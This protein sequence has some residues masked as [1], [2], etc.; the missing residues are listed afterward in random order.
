MKR[1]SH[2]LVYYTAF[3][4]LGL[5]S[6]CLGPTLS[7]LAENTHSSLSA[8]SFLFTARSGGYLLGSL[9]AGWLY[10]RYRGHPLMSIALVFVALALFFVPLTPQLWLTT[11]VILLLGISESVLDVGT[12]TLL[13]WAYKDN[14]GPFM[15]G[16]HFAFGLGAFLSPIIVAQAV[17][18]TQGITWA[19]WSL[20]LLVLI[21]LPFIL[22]L[23]SP[24][25][26]KSQPDKKEEK[27]HPSRPVWLLLAVIF[28]FFIYAG[29][30]ISLGNWIYSYAVATKIATAAGAAYLNSA[31]WGAFTV[32]RLLGIPLSTRLSPQKMI[33]FDLLL[34]LVGMGL[35][36]AGAGTVVL[37]WMGVIIAG[38]AI[39]SV[40]PT[41][42]NFAERRLTLTGKL[43]GWFFVGTSAGGMLF[44]W[45]VGQFFE[46]SGPGFTMVLILICILVDLAIFASIN[47]FSQKHERATF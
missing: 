47:Y 39:A 43:T 30:E 14:V 20:A 26:Q 24:S 1:W 40:F 42:L 25:I 6:A 41:M 5:A 16:L 32:G 11:L 45:L 36:F 22:R 44:P 29:T 2:A 33:F 34:A 15:N 21:A 28:F 8:I 35:I 46:S 3:I 19:Y 13:V 38:L 7:G 37:T 31:F 23:P 9:L 27:Q 4:A 17:L 10:D 18:F 12:N